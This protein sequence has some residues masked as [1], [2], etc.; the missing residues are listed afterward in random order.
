MAALYFL[1][2]FNV[3]LFVPLPYFLRGRF[4][5]FSTP[6]NK[7]L[8]TQG[9]LSFTGKNGP[10]YCCL[11]SSIYLSLCL[12]LSVW[13]D[14]DV[15]AWSSISRSHCGRLSPSCNKAIVL[16]CLLLFL[17]F[18]FFRAVA[19]AVSPLCF[20][21]LGCRAVFHF[22]SPFLI[23]ATI[24]AVFYGCVAVWRKYGSCTVTVH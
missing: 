14:I 6:R 22:S 21:C 13:N 4:A 7:S 11:F 1:H 16:F 15:L 12:K 9:H 24:K 10:L 20:S 2:T 8:L 3:P 5:N 23:Q 18:C 17:F 19:M